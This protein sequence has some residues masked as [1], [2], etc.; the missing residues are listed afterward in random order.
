MGTGI[1]T[2][3]AAH[4]GAVC[5]QAVWPAITCMNIWKSPLIREQIELR[6]GYYRVPELSGLGIE[7]DQRAL[8]HYA[9][10]Y[11]WVDLP[12]H[13]YRYSRAND[14]VTY[15]P[16]AKQGLEQR[17]PAEGMPVCEAGCSWAPIADDGT[18]RYAQLFDAVEKEGSVRWRETRTAGRARAGGP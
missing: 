10:D 4:L 15:Y 18:K 14:E 3:W 13:L 2:T 12:R 1:T 8:K 16:G 17:Y 6:G 11:T 7:V 9:V 5:R